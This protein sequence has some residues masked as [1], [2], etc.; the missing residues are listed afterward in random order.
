M[1]SDPASS[2]TKNSWDTYWQGAGTAAAYSAEGSIHP[3]ISGFWAELFHSSKALFDSPRI[4]DLA[5]GNGALVQSALDAF[6]EGSA[7]ITCVDISGKA[8]TSIR[9]RYPAV[10]AIVGDAADTGLPSRAFD[11]VTSQFGVEYAGSRAIE[12]AARLLAE[13]GRLGCLLHHE[14]S[15]I[16][17]DCVTGLDAVTRVR[18]SRFIPLATAFFSAGFDAV[19]GADRAR[20]EKAGTLLNPAIR[21]VEAAVEDHGP[22]VAGGVIAALYNDVK[23]IH[24]RI[25]N[26]EPS[27]GLDW[28]QNMDRQL[29]DYVARMSTMHAAA[30]DEQALGEFRDIVTAAGCTVTESGPLFAPG[31]TQPLAWALL[32]SR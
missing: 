24:Q 21:V 30:I 9:E 2:A 13:N 20:Y 28:L 26:Y 3:S 8:I 22:D 32:A 15:S 16:H 27:E 10:N 4:V 1:K 29:E 17:L 23:R 7:A 18:E 31:E 12:E 11:I 19:R 14:G 6:G 25:Q 5:S